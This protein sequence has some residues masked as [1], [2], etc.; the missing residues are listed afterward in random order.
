MVVKSVNYIIK[1]TRRPA[2]SPC[3]GLNTAQND[4][5]LNELKTKP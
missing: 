4:A 3:F 2:H 5:V 1:Q